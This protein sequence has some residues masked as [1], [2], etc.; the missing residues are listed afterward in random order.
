MIQGAVFAGSLD[1]HLRA[2]ASA[3]GRIIWDFDTLR[4]FVTVNQVKARGGS[5]TGTGPSIAGGFVYASAGYSRSPMIGGN[6][7]LAFSVDGK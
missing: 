1:G 5:I 3:D 6:V 2:Y 4:D 7:L